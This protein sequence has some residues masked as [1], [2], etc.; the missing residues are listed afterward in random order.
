MQLF[1]G[2]PFEQSIA[3]AWVPVHHCKEAEAVLSVNKAC[4]KT[5]PAAIILYLSPSSGCHTQ[6][7]HTEQ[8]M[9]MNVE[10]LLQIYLISLETTFGCTF[11]L[12]PA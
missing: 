5:Y 2:V 8:Q 11:Y 6:K 9:C 10:T 3:S 7:L 1:P 12:P 4:Q